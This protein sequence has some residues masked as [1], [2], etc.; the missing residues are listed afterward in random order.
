MSPTA[1]VASIVVDH[2][3]GPLLLDCVRTLLDESS[4]P[5]V[6]VENGQ[7]DSTELALSGPDN[8]DVRAQVTIV[9]PG[10]NLGYG[11]G[12]NRGLAVLAPD[13]PYV[14]VCNPDVRV[15]PGALASMVATLEGRPTWAL[16]GP[17][18]VND[19]GST[20]PSVRPFPSMTDAVG[21]A[22]LAL[23]NPYNKFSRRYRP[24]VPDTD[25]PVTADWI[26]GACFLARRSAFEE[27]GGFDES[28]FMYAEDMDLCWRAH[29][30]GWA[31]GFDPKAEIAHIQGTSTGR[32]PYRM[33]VA[34]HRSAYRFAVRTTK[35]WRRL[36]LPL[37]AA[38]LGVRLVV[39]CTQVALGHAAK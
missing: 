37:A 7:P 17:R 35:G 31:V 33:L 14:L 16:V 21:H 9:H 23:F 6:A 5:I 39:A 26:S 11:A 13:I 34:H 36:A 4:S 1:S 24:G 32:R 18:I 30:A 15:H 20:Y 8:R 2:E 28:Y 29:Q 10:R 27:L 3:A 12:A 19:D 22:L 38:V 25:L